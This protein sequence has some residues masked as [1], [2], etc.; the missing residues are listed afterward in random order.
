MKCNGANS[1][2]A[3]FSSLPDD[4]SLN[5][6]EY[7]IDLPTLYSL[8]QTN[9]YLHTLL[10]EEDTKDTNN[11]WFQLIQ[12]RFQINQSNHYSLLKTKTYGATNWKNAYCNLS[13]AKNARIPKCRYTSKKKVVFAKSFSSGKKNA[14]KN[15]IHNDAALWIMLNHTE[16]CNTRVFDDTNGNNSQRFIQ[17]QIC[18]QNI[19]SNTGR[20]LQFNFCES[21]L[22]LSHCESRV[23]VMQT[24]QYQPCIV[25]RSKDDEC[26]KNMKR[27]SYTSVLDENDFLNNVVSCTLGPLEFVIAVVSI[28]CPSDIIYET[29]F[30]CR[31]QSLHVPYIMKEEVPYRSS[32]SHLSAVMDVYNNSYNEKKNVL[33]YDPNPLGWCERMKAKVIRADFIKENEIWNHYNIL[34]GGCLSRVY[35]SFG[36]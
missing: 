1:N 24:G 16:N 22:T 29:D 17:L 36:L 28:Q 26:M 31:V 10:I 2:M 9:K 8:L 5:I 3:S 25:Y 35:R 15:K 33:L 27:P 7:I 23:N 6:I 19:K 11:V 14:V 18:V 21:Y 30:L 34:P 32:T 12:K 20:S 13:S 4:V